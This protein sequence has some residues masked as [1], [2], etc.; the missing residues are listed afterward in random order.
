MPQVV[1]PE[2]LDAERA[3]AAWLQR[4]EEY[5]LRSLPYNATPQVRLDVHQQLRAQ[6]SGLNPLPT[7]TTV[8][9]LLQAIIDRAMRIAKY[10]QQSLDIIDRLMRSLPYDIQHGREFA[11]EKGAALTL[12]TEAVDLLPVDSGEE[13]KGAAARLA[14]EPVLKRYQQYRACQSLLQGLYGMMPRANQA[15]KEAAWRSLAAALEKLP[16]GTA[17]TRLQEER[18]KVV[19]GAMAL[20]EKRE[21]SERR[22]AAEEEKKMEA[23][24]KRSAAESTVRMAI[25]HVDQVLKELEREGE[26]EFDGFND[27]WDTWRKMKELVGPLLVEELMKQP[28][29]S[30][31]AV[32]KRIGVLVRKSLP[33]VVPE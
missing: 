12:M 4:W 6:L 31:E 20:V 1:E 19:A 8:Q 23:A 15:E 24:S 7:D 32:R 18:D 27:R 14:V 28:E 22:R 16:V 21:E 2:A 29:M 33:S 9:G 3:R 17:Q 5:A 30:R 13:L 26:V 10:R 11:V 25:S